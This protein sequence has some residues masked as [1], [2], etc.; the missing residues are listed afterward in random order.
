MTA[1][2]GKRSQRIGGSKKP[3][4]RRKKQQDEVAAD[5]EEAQAKPDAETLRMQQ[6]DTLEV[7]FEI[8][9][10]VLKQVTASGLAAPNF[11]G[12]LKQAH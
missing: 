9:F 2:A 12:E 11:T 6:S 7:L 1:A 8:F 10:R 5:F 4:K 3:P